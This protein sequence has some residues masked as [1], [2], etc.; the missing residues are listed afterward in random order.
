MQ[1]LYNDIGST[2]CATRRADFVIA[3]TLAQLVE[4]QEGRRFL[5]LACGTGNY[6]NALASIGGSWSGCDISEVMIS[7][8]RLKN[9]AIDW[10]L[11]KAD[12]LP[13]QSG[14]FDGAM[15]TLAIHHFPDLLKPFQEVH[16]VLNQGAFVLFTAF[17]HQMRKYWL[18]HY[19]PEMMKSSIT[20]MPAQEVV[21]AALQS[22]GFELEK[23]T[24]FYVINELQDL[25]L[26]SGKERPDQYLDPVVRANI[27]S[28]ASRCSA[29]ELNTGL[30]RLSS[31]IESG[32]FSRVASSYVSTRGDYAYV[33]AKKRCD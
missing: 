6:T 10:Q 2:Y 19:F 23:I 11:S 20:Q 8:A 1:P 15:C 26:Y 24:P 28:F 12:S 9:S 22:A 13:Y 27:S 4:V 16:R 25:F 17:P 3:K 21:T 5:D 31:D 7:Q 29:A 32:E 30:Q 14:F 33:V 18:C